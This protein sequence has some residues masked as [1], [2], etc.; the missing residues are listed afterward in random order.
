M[1]RPALK[2]A[3][4]AQIKGNLGTIFVI[5][6]LIGLLCCIP[7]FGFILAPGLSIS[8]CM[9]YLNLTKGQS[10]EVGHMFSG[11]KVLGKAWWL[12]ILTAFFVFLWSLLLF[13]PGIVKS[14]AYSMAPYVLADNPTF[15]AREA[16]RE[17]KRIT[18]GHKGQLFILELSFFGWMLLQVLVTNGIGL[19]VGS[20][21]GQEHFMVSVASYVLS[22][23]VSLILFPYMQL[24][25][26]QYYNYL[27]G[28]R[29]AESRDEYEIR[30]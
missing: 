16:L 26:A 2:A 13:I 27:T 9:I 15:T 5:V 23:V 21:L 6:L 17:S 11:T 24:T 4:K 1:D 19:A 22:G 18:Q 12:Q 20:M 14:Y 30:F 8:L 28:W 7:L 25:F 29:S 10:P 3:A